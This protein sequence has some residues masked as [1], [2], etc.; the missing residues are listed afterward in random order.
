M[1]TGDFDKLLVATDSRYRLSL[2]VAKRAMQLQKGFPSLLDQD[3]YP[4]NRQG[5]SRDD[6][7]VAM[8]EL[9]LDK[10]LTWGNDLPSDAD[11]QRAFE[12]EH[13]DDLGPYPTTPVP[14]RAGPSKE[15]PAIG[16][17][18]PPV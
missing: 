1:T 11:L 8:Q 16:Q 15:A 10:D 3:E 2:I 18:R 5:T 7:A 9:V 17:R 4:E 12:A 13:K 6:V 14:E